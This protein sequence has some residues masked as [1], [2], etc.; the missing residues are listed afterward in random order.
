MHELLSTRMAEI[1]P[2]CPFRCVMVDDDDDEGSEEEAGGRGDAKYRS[3][4]RWERRHWISNIVTTCIL[5][6][7]LKP[8]PEKSQGFERDEK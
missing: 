8:H 2:G 3:S 1:S 7:N 4:C 6:M 5:L